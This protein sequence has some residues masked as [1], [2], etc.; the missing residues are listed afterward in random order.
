MDSK[1]EPNTD[2][3]R[4]DMAAENSDTVALNKKRARRVSFAELTSIH[5]F[6]RDEEFN[7]TSQSENA[8]MADDSPAELGFGGLLQRS[9]EFGSEDDGG[10]NLE[11]EIM[12]MQRNFLRP[13]GSPSSGGSTMG[14]SSSN[15]ED[16]FFG[17]VSANFIRPGRLSDSV[18]S[19]DNHDLTMDSTAFSM[20]FHSI[21]GSESVIDL[22][23]P[24]GG[25]LFFEEKTP[26]N[27]NKESSLVFTSGKP[28]VP[29]SFVSATEASENQS[30]NDMSLVWGNS[31]KYD[32]EKLSPELDAILAENRK[33]LLHVIAPDDITSPKKNS[34]QVSSS[35][36]QGNYDSVRKGSERINSDR[37]TDGD[38]SDARIQF[39]DA[40]G[41]RGSLHGGCSPKRS[42]SMLG[43]T[44]SHTESRKPISSP[45][46]L[47]K[48]DFDS[49]LLVSTSS[50]VKLKQTL[51]TTASPSQPW[52]VTS[53]LPEKPPSSLLRN[54]S[55][56][57]HETETPIQKSISKLE[58]LEKAA[59]SSVFSAKVDKST[60]KSL[61]FSKSPNAVEKN[62]DISRI[63]FMEDSDSEEKLASV[64]RST[65]R[66]FDFYMDHVRGE[67]ILEE[68]LNQTMD[69]KSPNALNAKSYSAGKSDLGRTSA[70]PSK[71]TLSGNNSIHSHFT[72]NFKSENSLK[73]ETKSS[74]SESAFIEGEKADTPI[75]VHSS[76]RV[77]DENLPASPGLLSSLSVD[78]WSRFKQM[79][80]SDKGRDI[81]PGRDPAHVN[82]SATDS[83]RTVSGRKN[84]KLRSPFVEVNRLN[85]IELRA[86][87]SGGTDMHNGKEIMQTTGHFSSPTKESQFQGVHLDVGDLT[88]RDTSSFEDNIPEAGSRMVSHE[89][90]SPFARRNLDKPQLQFPAGSPSRKEPDDKQIPKIASPRIIQL[91]GGLKSYSANKRNIGLLLRDPQHRT[92]ITKLERSPKLLKN[93]N[94]DTENIVYSID[95][96][97]KQNGQEK[98]KLAD[99]YSKFTEDTRILISGSADKLSFKMIDVLEDMLVDQQRLK[100]YEMLQHGV[101]PQ[102]EIVLHDLQLEKITE[103]KSL[104]HKVVFE[105]AK[106]QLKHVKRERLLKRL[107]LLS[108]RMEDSK[109]LRANMALLPMGICTSTNGAVG[110]RLLSVNLTKEHEVCHDRLTTMRQTLEALDRKILTLKRTFHSC[111]KFKAEPG[112]GETITL[113]TEHLAKKTSRRF[114]RLDTQMWVV[115]G[116]SS[117][118]GQHKVILNHLDLIIQSIQIIAGP[119]SSVRSSFKLN[120]TN[121]TK[122]FPNMD[123]CIAFQFVFNTDTAHKYASAKNLVQETQVTS[124]LLGSLLDVV[125][126]VQTAHIEFQNL[127][128]TCFSSPSVDRLDLMLCFFNFY[129]GGKVSFTFDLSCLKRGIYPSEILPLQLSSPIAS[130]TN[131]SSGII[132]D[133]IRDAVKDVRTGY[134]RI[135]RLCRCLSRIVQTITA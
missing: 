27:S 134:T 78:L 125:E 64:N 57:H 44:A 60:I 89:S 75:F 49:S 69:G 77:L 111:C 6:D 94:H 38:K 35:V 80:N 108:S 39:G 29:R 128:Q 52:R 109:T 113:V 117:L 114:I 17:P 92:E 102:S 48:D 101:A 65:E 18:A 133:K 132:L 31:N 61:D 91:S 97:T 2:G 104:L 42:T 73:S 53:P 58:L 19:D 43:V 105:K 124:S 40:N 11:D 12:E 46:Q 15:D 119:T 9:K 90:V 5:F 71:K 86:T 127:T 93:G 4:R 88:N 70:S 79:E 14:S 37:V 135:L 10:D 121:I 112:V 47:S 41:S 98:R 62:Y 7:E 45:H 1:E 36:S 87:D 34:G 110:N 16:N 13:I 8:K 95:N 72:T 21:A 122:N 30:S 123:A 81:T 107:N 130:C 129:S 103:T 82:S 96:K 85:M 59:S 99:A 106:L 84:G 22:K 120:E 100:V 50:P 25:Q 118:N 83:I 66:N 74:L 55:I 63:S 54:G 33:N 56:E 116:L 28:H 32:Y 76:D 67:N 68:S 51:L 24:T 3:D 20:H 26:N 126:E 131:P 23:T 115:Q